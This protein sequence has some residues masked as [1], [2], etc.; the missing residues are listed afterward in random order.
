MPEITEQKPEFEP[1]PLPPRLRLLAHGGPPSWH[2]QTYCSA[3]MRKGHTQ[4]QQGPG[5]QRQSP[6]S[7]ELE[8]GGGCPMPS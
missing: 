7:P 2:I 1:G 3:G 4:V 8:R 5:G 6:S